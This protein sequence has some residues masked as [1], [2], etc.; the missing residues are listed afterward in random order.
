M[1]TRPEASGQSGHSGN[2]SARHSAREL[3]EQGQ[4]VRE[5][6]SALAGTVRNV[7]QGWETLLRDSLERRPYATLAVAAGLGYVL[8]G[9]LPRGLLRAAIGIGGRLAVEQAVGRWAAGL[10]DENREG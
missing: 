6:I 8:G 3:V 1:N 5:D 2:G 7:A 10:I 9:G 4:K